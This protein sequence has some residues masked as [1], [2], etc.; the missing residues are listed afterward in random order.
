MTKDI[1]DKTVLSRRLALGR[2]GLL[3]A[4]A[5]TIPAF[6]TLSMA[7]AGSRSSAP[8]KVS[9]PS[10]PSTPSAASDPSAPSEPSAPSRASR[11]SSA[12]SPSSAAERACGPQNSGDTAY[13]QCLIDNGLA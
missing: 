7:H 13:E 12:T 6:T 2:L 3:A 5:Y 1:E 11:P 10:E 9:K 4:T 8:S